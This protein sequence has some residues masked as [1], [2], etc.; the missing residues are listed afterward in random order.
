[1]LKVECEQCKAPYQIDERRVPPTG[2]KMRCPKCGHSFLV[3]NPDAPTPLAPQVAQGKPTSPALPKKTIVGVQAP[4]AAAP[5]PRP[6][7]P[8]PPAA[9][10]IPPMRGGLPSDFPAAL[11]SLDEVD[12]PAL[13]GD[14]PVVSPDLPAARKPG[15][16]AAGVTGLPAVA[17]SAPA[18]AAPK[19]QSPFPPGPSLEL[20]L[21]AVAADLP[22]TVGSPLENLPT[23][24]G[25]SFEIDL[26]SPV[27]AIGLP[28]ARPQPVSRSVPAAAPKTSASP[29]AVARGGAPGAPDLPVI[30]GRGTAADLPIVSAGLPATA[31]SLPSPVGAGLPVPA[32]S[33]PSPAASLPAPAGNLPSPASNLPSPARGFGEI[34]LPNP[35]ELESVRPPP[36]PAPAPPARSLDASAPPAA[37]AG[38]FGEIELPREGDVAVP[39]L[40]PQPARGGRGAG[41]QS[42]SVR[43]AVPDSAD[44]G[45]LDLG[46]VPPSAPHARDVPAHRAADTGGMA[47][48]EVDFGGESAAAA[49][50]EAD[51]G[52]DEALSPAKSLPPAGPGVQAAATA[53]VS[54]RPPGPRV[55]SIAPPARRSLGK[56]IGAVVLVLAL[57]GGG[58][59]Q[60]TPYGAFGY[61][62]IGDALHAKDYAA[63]TSSTVAAVDKTLASDTYDDAKSAIEAAVAARTA[64]PRIKALTAYAAVVDY[65]TTVRHGPDVARASRA[66]QLIG[67]LS[68]AP[69]T[70]YLDVAQAAQA[71]EGGD[72]DKARKLLDAAGR[73]YPGDP[74]Q[75]DVSLLR[76][77]IELGARD[78][79]AA[80]GAFKTAL[81]LAADAR[82]HFGLARAYDLLGDAVNA[83]KEIDATLAASPL[84][85]GALTL[86]ARRKSAPTDDAS[87]FKDLTTV[88]DGAA[89]VKASPVEL[90]RAYAARAWVSLE[91]GAA[92][93][94]RDAFGQA[95][96]LDPR[97]VAALNGEGRLLLSEGRYTEALSRFDTALQFDAS[98]PES[99]ANDAEAKLALERLADAKQQ[100]TD[101]KGR[102]PKSIPILLLLGRVE[103][104]LGNWDAAE[105]DLRAAISF[106]DV[107]R[108]DAVQP[109]VALSELLSARGHIADAKAAL[110]DARK[111]LPPS[112]TLDRAVG[113]VAE[114]QGDYDGAI[115]QYRSSLTKDPKD[116]ATHFRLA[117]V[118]RRVR[119]FDDAGT[120]LNQVAA[121][122]KDYP[123]L[124]LERGLLYEESGDVDKA[125]EQFKTALARAPDDP[126]LQLRVGAA[127]VVIGRPDDALVMLRKVL[128]K[129]PTSAEAHHYI[130]RA[131]M[132][133]G[134][135]QQAD[136]LRYL[137]RA[138]DLDPNRAEFHVYL[139][140]AAN[141]AQ[142]A[143]LELARD[144]I[145]RSLALDK[146]NPEAYWQ[147]GVLERMEG[148]VDDAIKDERRALELRPSRYEAHATLAECWEDKNDPT[149]ALGEWAR[150]AAG[151][152][153]P[154]ADGSVAHPY[155]RYRYGKLLL[156]RGQS[157][158]A[159]AQLLPAVQTAERDQGARPGWLAP[160]EF[161]TA[162]AL[163]KNGRSKD[164]VEHYRR[165]LEIAPVNSPDRADAQRA[166]AQLAPGGN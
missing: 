109:Y 8:A 104:H 2:L 103:Q 19:V 27:A 165:F 18:P 99:I 56:S 85:P 71:A 67:E 163:R 84:H 65:A 162:E 128:E 97:N 57:L 121:V 93:D 14:L 98:S 145:D 38:G 158:A 124:S 77:E 136:A 161:L 114:A 155:W 135:S 137:K 159:L 13:T 55:Q 74:I 134:V 60:L 20:D 86:R 24:A 110:D 46:D 26:P 49:P 87:A 44:F 48:G 10:P 61:L 132:L 83:K 51:I 123:G 34:E 25:A 164:A 107:S 73:H 42:A 17:R 23:K 64:A 160:L 37:G 6:A 16:G 139:A 133:Q 69:E 153:P 63:T 80:V 53:P 111:R 118:L 36:V 88:L 1:M 22:A 119:R 117:V 94:A 140:W 3:T 59:L 76:G 141:D 92:S 129:R 33:L 32:A 47:F 9:P 91:R 131:L 66:K 11:G 100:L 54:I 62:T 28:V 31:A 43:A 115:A 112:A 152:P 102:F 5:P 144:E 156:D 35:I 106:A 58:A 90:S 89:R 7:P 96:K 154:T 120:E 126:D 125:I 105:Q 29:P 101:A 40:T 142:P 146:L 108:P 30:A 50:M 41:A 150:V 116:V 122:D 138:V 75:I 130:G 4:I 15:A 95:V 52:V 143:Q 81:G 127:Y 78:G 166:L 147:R 39:S 68:E 21:P 72:A 149:T 79:A 45:D 12:L 151:E 148:A 157:G 70:K 113:E 82:A